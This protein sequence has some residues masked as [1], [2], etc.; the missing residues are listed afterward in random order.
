MARPKFTDAQIS[1]DRAQ[2]FL[3]LDEEGV[4]PAEVARRLNRTRGAISKWVAE[5]RQAEQALAGGIAQSLRNPSLVPW[6]TPALR[7]QVIARL[8][9]GDASILT[10]GRYRAWT[11]AS[12]RHAFGPNFVIDHADMDSDFVLGDIY[13]EPLND[14][15]LVRVLTSWNCTRDAGGVWRPPAASTTA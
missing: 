3:W 12:I 13:D 4:R 6:A 14:D 2:A 10:R 5:R 8:T 7:A 9:V 15:L 11:M 1:R